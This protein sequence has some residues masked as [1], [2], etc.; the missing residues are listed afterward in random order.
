MRR[1]AAN[2]LVRHGQDDDADRRS[3]AARERE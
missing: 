3:R 2:A 1:S